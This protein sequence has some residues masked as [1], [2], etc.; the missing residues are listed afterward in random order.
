[1]KALNPKTKLKM[2]VV[3]MSV[4]V[5]T[6]LVVSTLSILGLGELKMMS[7]DTHS[8]WLLIK[9]FASILVGLITFIQLGNIALELSVE[10]E[11]L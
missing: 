2:V 9:I 10:A 11:Q 1:M 4:L 7:Q 5:V 8:N 6:I 3:A